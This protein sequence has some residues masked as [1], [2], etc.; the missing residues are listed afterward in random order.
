MEIYKD[1]NNVC[2]FTYI[3]SS[4]ENYFEFELR[5]KTEFF[6]GFGKISIIKD[7]IQNCVEDINAADMNK[8]IKIEDS[9][10]YT[11]VEYVP[12]KYGQAKFK[13]QIRGF[14]DETYF[15]FSIDVDQ[16]ILYLINEELKLALY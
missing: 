16:T 2:N 7:F 5:I 12:Q 8:V 11:Y 13:G 10:S 1:D 4:Y 14:L 9:N 6:M 15:V 3:G